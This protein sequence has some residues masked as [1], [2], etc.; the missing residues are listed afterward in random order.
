M[1]KKTPHRGLK[2][3]VMNSQY[4][5]RFTNSNSRSQS[6]NDMKTIHS[7]DRA[8]LAGV[9][10]LVKTSINCLTSKRLISIQEA[11]HEMNELQLVISSE[12]M[13]RVSLRGCLYK[14]KRKSEPDPKDFVYQYADRSSEYSNMSLSR[15]FY[16]VWCKKNFYTD[17]DTKRK[18]KRILIPQG[19]NC[20]PRHPIDYNYARGML[21]MHKPWS[22]DKP[23]RTNNKQATIDE[24]K[25]MLE[26]RTVPTSVWTEYMRAVKYS[27][28]KK[29]EIVAQRGVIEGDACIDDM[30]PEEADQHLAWS[31]ANQFTASRIDPLICKD[32]V[33]D[34][35]L[36]HNWS[37]PFF[38]GEREITCPGEDYCTQLREQRFESQKDPNRPPEI[39]LRSN[40]QPYSIDDLSDQQRIIV[41]ATV[42]TVLK[43]L[44]ND[45]DYKPLR[46]T[47]MGMGGCGKS[48][49][50]NTIISIIVKLTKCNDTVKVAAPSGNAAWNVRGCTLHSLLKINVNTPWSSLDEKSQ[51]SLCRKLLNLLILMVDERSM[52]SADVIF[53][54]E[55]HVREC[56][57]NGHNKRERWGGVPVVIVFGDDYQLPPIDKTGVI[58]LFA[59]FKDNKKPARATSRRKNTQICEYIGFKLLSENLTEEVFRLDINYRTQDKDDNELMK[60][61]RVGEQTEDDVTRLKNLHLDKF[62][63]DPQ[64]KKDIESDSRTLFAFAKQEERQKKNTEMLIKTHKRLKVPVARLK[65]VFKSAA[66]HKTIYQ[67]HFRR[68]KIIHQFDVCV[69][70]QVCLE[71]ANIDPIS[72]IYVGAI[73]TVID[74]IYD[75]SLGPNGK[76]EDNLPLYIIVDFPSFKPEEGQDVW[77]K[78]NPTVSESPRH[79]II[80]D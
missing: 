26:N 23:L 80:S 61:L 71:N 36:K 17:E 49:V 48:M 7:A 51:E 35:G 9:Q 25:T 76:R 39:P 5:A 2:N 58:H 21:V 28:E 19:L 69:G 15:Y 29:I 67:S 79:Y 14:L 55:E 66:G 1:R 4:M 64:F 31:H 42:D 32:Q 65:S 43:F 74:I 45:D 54:A 59:K 56:A 13:T 52:L 41:L 18:M 77:D 63:H 6:F 75:K 50:I 33:V 16:K 47:V 70:S 40:G 12:Y 34:I 53:G 38:K 8:D 27:Q 10:S 44:N 37:E 20:R 11:V 78:K 46:A 22:F 57:Y 30:D 24:F 60:R 72:G 3:T 68:L 62:N 73:G